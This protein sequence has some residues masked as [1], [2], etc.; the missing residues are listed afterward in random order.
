[1][2]QQAQLVALLVHHWDGLP[3]LELDHLRARQ[4]GWQRDGQPSMPRGRQREGGGQQA[5]VAG[6]WRSGRRPVG[7]VN[8]G[9]VSQTNCCRQSA[10]LGYMLVLVSASSIHGGTLALSPHNRR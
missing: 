9:G 5:R 1:M 7:C 8:P 4:V 10:W 3:F 2:L 6:G